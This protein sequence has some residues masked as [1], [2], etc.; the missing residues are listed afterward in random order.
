M[1]GASAP[2]PSA[3]VAAIWNKG[4][5]AEVPPTRGWPS[6]RRSPRLI[7]KNAK[8]RLAAG[9]AEP[10]RPGRTV[11]CPYPCRQRRR[12]RSPRRSAWW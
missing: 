1:G 2:T 9:F 10:I 6:L 8:A 5:A 3:Q 11:T 7:P 12:P 4:V